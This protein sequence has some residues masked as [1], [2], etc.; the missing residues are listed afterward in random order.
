MSVCKC[1]L[2]KEQDLPLPKG[3]TAPAKSQPWKGDHSRKGREELLVFTLHYLKLHMPS[4]SSMITF[5]HI[6]PF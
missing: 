1:F 2:K 6:R 3:K 5:I 4:I